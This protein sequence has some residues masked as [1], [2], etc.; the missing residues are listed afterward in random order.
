MTPYASLSR[1][2]EAP[3]HCTEA[4]YRNGGTKLFK[5]VSLVAGEIRNE[6]TF[7]WKKMDFVVDRY[8]HTLIKLEVDEW[9]IPA[10][11]DSSMVLLGSADDFQSILRILREDGEEELA[12]EFCSTSKS[13]LDC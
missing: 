6:Q 5:F 8:F 2:A 9:S 11:L 1:S 7:F 3:I 12:N 4:V 10:S 13:V